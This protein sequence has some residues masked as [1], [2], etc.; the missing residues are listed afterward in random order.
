MREDEW[1][2]GYLRRCTART[3]RILV[4]DFQPQLPVYTERGFAGGMLVFLGLHWSSPEDQQR[5]VQRLEQES[6]PIVISRIPDALH[7]WP[8]VSAYVSREYTPAGMSA[9]GRNADEQFSVS[10][11]RDAGRTISRDPLWHLPCFAE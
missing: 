10:I 9:F 4:V 11:K 7:R 8:I 1:I 3:D 6:V 2:S 5:I